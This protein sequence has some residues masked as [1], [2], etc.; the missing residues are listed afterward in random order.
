MD[1]S[2]LKESTFWNK[3][4]DKAAAILDTNKN[5][6]ISRADYMLYRERFSQQPISQKHFNEFVK[7]QDQFLDHVNL[8]DNSVKYTYKEMREKFIE[9]VKKAGEDFKIF[10]ENLFKPL[11]LNEDGVISFEEWKSYYEVVG[12]PA[13]YSRASFDA[14]DKSGDEKIT[15]EEFVAYNYEFYC[16]DEDKMRSSILYGPLD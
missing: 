8:T 13:M 7:S 12:I 6:Y 1:L 16:S 11:D 9:D 2:K 14:M 15:L 4:I 3:K 5:G 10:L